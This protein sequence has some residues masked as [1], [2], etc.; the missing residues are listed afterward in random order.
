MTSTTHHGENYR[1]QALKYYYGSSNVNPCCWLTGES[2]KGADGVT[3][4]HIYSRECQ[5]ANDAYVAASRFFTM[6]QKR[7]VSIQQVLDTFAIDGADRDITV[8]SPRNI[9][10]LLK[11][12]EEWFDQLAIMFIHSPSFIRGQLIC[13]VLKEELKPLSYFTRPSDFRA[14]RVVRVLPGKSFGDLDGKALQ[15]PS[16]N[17][18]SYRLL[19]CHAQ[20]AC[21]TNGLATHIDAMAFLTLRASVASSATAGD[22]FVP[23]REWVQHYMGQRGKVRVWKIA[24]DMFVSQSTLKCAIRGLDDLM[25]VKENDKQYI[26]AIRA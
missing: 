26:C 1:K 22:N 17:R 6:A 14:R 23:L 9:M 25:L 11:S 19:C 20:D 7:P 21:A 16:D 8:N 2:K 13:K 12:V 24:R 5:S 18:P 4:A 3:A 15:F 10:F